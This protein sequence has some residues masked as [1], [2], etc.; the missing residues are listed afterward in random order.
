MITNLT[1]HCEIIATPPLLNRQADGGGPT[2]GSDLQSWEMAAPDH[3]TLGIHLG[4]DVDAML[5]V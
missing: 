5:Q 2:G 4:E 1:V 3:A